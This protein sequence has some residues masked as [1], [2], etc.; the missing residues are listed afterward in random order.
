MVVVYYFHTSF[1]ST[2][3]ASGHGFSRMHLLESFQ[4]RLQLMSPEKDFTEELAVSYRACFGLELHSGRA[5]AGPQAQSMW[6]S[7]KD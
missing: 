2:L 1:T 5:A 3:W 7:G 4:V 6:S